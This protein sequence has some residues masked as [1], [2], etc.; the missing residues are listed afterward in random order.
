MNEDG[1]LIYGFQSPH[2]VGSVCCPP[3]AQCGEKLGQLTGMS[4]CDGNRLRAQPLYILRDATFEEYAAQHGS[5]PAIRNLHYYV[6]S[7]D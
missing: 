1:V 5:A 4:D 6:V 2:R 3:C 7:T